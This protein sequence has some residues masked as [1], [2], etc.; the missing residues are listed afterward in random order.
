MHAR[1][2]PGVPDFVFGRE[3][4]VVFI[5]GC[6]WH[7]C[8]TCA[9]TLPATNRAY[10]SSKIAANVKRGVQINT[11]LGDLGFQV[12]RIWEHE[13]RSRASV[14]RLVRAIAAMH[15][16][17]RRRSHYTKNGR[18]GARRRNGLRG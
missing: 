14:S 12:V 7:R 6:F 10:W 9:R 15:P 17:T 4:I 8:P 13:L 2:L 11:Q 18:V 3:K 1:T 5:D 16:R